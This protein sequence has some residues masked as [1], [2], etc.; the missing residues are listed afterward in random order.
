M[1][2]PQ[3]QHTKTKSMNV[4]DVASELNNELPGIYLDEYIDFSDT[5][6]KMDPK[7]YLINLTLNAYDYDQ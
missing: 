4:Y 7:Y 5:K 6:S 1:L 3:K 2:D